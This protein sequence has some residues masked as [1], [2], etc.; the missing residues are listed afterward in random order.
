MT[1]IGLIN[2]I[3]LYC[4]ISNS[5]RIQYIVKWKSLPVTNKISLAQIKAPIKKNEYELTAWGQNGLVCGIDE[6]GR[7]CLAGP[8]V[9]AAVIIPPGKKSPLIKDSKVLTPEERLK[10]L[11]WIEK[12]CWYATGIVHNRIIDSHNIWQATLIAMKKALLHLLASCPYAPEA[13]LVDAM[14]LQLLDTSYANIPVYHFTKGESRSISI[15]AAS[16]VAK[17]KRDAIMARLDAIIPGY[18]FEQ[19]K[20]YS[21]KKHMAALQIQPP[22]IIHRNSFIDELDFVSSKKELDE[23]DQ[24][25]TICGSY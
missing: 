3:K 18:A 21:T 13:V 20:G 12:H 23:S 16:I 8:V 4:L 10:A 1:L 14:P 17:V 25:Q 15:A 7:G 6:V 2:E 24:Q 22:S 11:I 9:T 5:T 19:H